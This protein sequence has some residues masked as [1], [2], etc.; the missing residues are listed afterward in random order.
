MDRIFKKMNLKLLLVVSTTI[1]AFVVSFICLSH[2]IYDIY[3]NLFYI[4]I[5]LACFCFGRKGFI[6]SVVLTVLH[7]S[8]CLMCN[9][10]AV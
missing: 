5:I 4:P 6:F 9:T 2:E 3:Q 8:I 1:V 7:T 10:E